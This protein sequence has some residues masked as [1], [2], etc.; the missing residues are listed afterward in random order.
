MEKKYN[1]LVE[2]INGKIRRSGV[3]VVGIPGGV[4][5]KSRKNMDLQGS[6]QKNSR[7]FTINL[8][9]NPRESTSKTSTSSTG[10]VQFFLEKPDNQM[11]GIQ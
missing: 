3:K 7:G 11:V 6:M 4:Q 9:G 10:G 8:T 2:D 1:P 5:K